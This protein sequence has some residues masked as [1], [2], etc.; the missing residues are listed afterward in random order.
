MCANNDDV[1]W[2]RTDKIIDLIQLI[3]DMITAFESNEPKIHTI[4]IKFNNLETVLF[5]KHLFSTVQSTKENIILT[6]FKDRKEFG[7]ASIHLESNLLD[8]ATLSRKLKPIEILDAISFV[9]ETAKNTGLQGGQH[10]HSRTTGDSATLSQKD[11]EGCR[12]IS[13]TGLVVFQIVAAE[14]PTVI[15]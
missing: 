13:L 11:D 8:L 6:K 15:S 1:S 2:V 12:N 7:L 4:I 10:P 9:C 5:E 14:N 3:V